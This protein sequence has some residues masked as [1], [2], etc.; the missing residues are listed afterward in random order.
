MPETLIAVMSGLSP[1]NSTASMAVL[2]AER[3]RHPVDVGVIQVISALCG[4]GIADAI[5]HHLGREVVFLHALEPDSLVIGVLADLHLAAMVRAGRGE[6][7]AV[8]AGAHEIGLDR[9]RLQAA[10]PSLL[11][12]DRSR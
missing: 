7:S 4:V 6:G 2:V 5:A 9:D 10:P 8:L 3:H 12:Q 11:E 1:G